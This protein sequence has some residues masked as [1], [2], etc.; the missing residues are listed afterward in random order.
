MQLLGVGRDRFEWSR[1]LSE[2]KGFF[3]EAESAAVQAAKK[4]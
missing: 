2:S 1:K 4:K 3:I